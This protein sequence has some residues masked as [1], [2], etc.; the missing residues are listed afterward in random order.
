MPMPKRVVPRINFM[1]RLLKGL[2]SSPLLIASYHRN[3]LL[4]LS[5]AMI[6]HNEISTVN[7]LY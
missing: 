1:A 4:H 3:Q 5:N 2:K 6:S 7:C